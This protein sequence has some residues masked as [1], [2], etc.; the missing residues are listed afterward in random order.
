[1]I[2]APLGEAADVAHVTFGFV[3]RPP[4]VDPTPSTSGQP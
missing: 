1:M 3:N 2:A 4:A